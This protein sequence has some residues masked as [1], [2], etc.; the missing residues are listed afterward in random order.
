[1]ASGSDGPAQLG[2]QRLDGVRCVD[3]FA[4]AFGEREERNDKVPV[5]TPA[6]RDRRILL[7][8][9]TLCEG[10]EGARSDLAIGSAIDGWQRLRDVLAILPSG[11]IHGMA[12]QVNDAG[13]NDRLRENR[14]DGFRK[15]LQ[16]IDDRDQNVLG[17]AGL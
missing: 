15:A 12:N 2:V 10:I 9:R 1:M 8:P 4:D 3:K 13:L 6:L 11:E 7:A 5:A 17:A 16:A 14:I